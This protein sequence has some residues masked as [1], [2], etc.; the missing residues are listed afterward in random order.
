MNI[1]AAYQEHQK[2][3]ESVLKSGDLLQ[4]VVQKMIAALESGAKV[5]WMGNG[6]SAA[7]AQHMAAELMVRYV[8]NRQPLASIALTTDSSLLT[9][10]SNDFEFETIFSRQVEALAQPGDVV[11]GMST[12]G[13]SANVLKAM[14]VAQEKGCLTIA[15]IGSKVS[16]LSETAD[17]CF[18][19]HSQQTARIQEAHTFLNHLICEGLDAHFADGNA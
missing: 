12:S 15:L 11:I 3:I 1:E 5:L 8:I 14:E 9:A 2:A 19:I 7:E 10:H 17:Y 16:P 13:T 6:G 18:P 4:E